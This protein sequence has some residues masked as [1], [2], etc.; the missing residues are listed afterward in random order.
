MYYLQ[1]EKV[2]L[3]DLTDLEMGNAFEI[4]TG[5]SHHSLR[6]KLSKF[7]LSQTK[8]NLKALN[9][10]LAKLKTAIDEPLAKK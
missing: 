8:I 4:L 7:I 3:K 9:I 10:L 1:R 6:Q 5:Y 2:I